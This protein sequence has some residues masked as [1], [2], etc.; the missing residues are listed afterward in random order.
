[1]HGNGRIVCV[2]HAPIITVCVLSFLAADY[3]NRCYGDVPDRDLCV[4]LDVLCNFTKASILWKMS[5]I[6]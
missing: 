6:F 4:S 3:S 2:I 1:M 5:M